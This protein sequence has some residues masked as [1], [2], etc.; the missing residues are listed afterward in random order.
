MICVMF[1]SCMMCVVRDVHVY[2]CVCFFIV[3]VVCVM[4]VMCVLY[5]LYAVC[6]VWCA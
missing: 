3:H 4:Y 6:D 5:V 2:I 1:M